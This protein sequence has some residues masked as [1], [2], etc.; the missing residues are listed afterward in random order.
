MAVPQTSTSLLLANTSGTTACISLLSVPYFSCKPLLAEAQTETSRGIWAGIS[1]R[2]RVA[3]LAAVSILVYVNSLLNGFTLDDGMYILGSKAVTGFDVKGL[4]TPVAFNNAFRP[5]TFFSFAVNW[6]LNGSKPFG[7]VFADLLLNAAT[8]LLLYLVLRTLLENMPRG[9][10]IA[11]VAA[12]LFAV[13]PIHT[14]AVASISNRSEILATGF[15]FAAWLFH[16][17]EKPALAVV[18]FVLAL[19]SKESAVAFLPLVVA[20]D[21]ARGRMQSAAK[22]GVYGIATVLY[23]VLLWHVE[24]GRFG[25]VSVSI[26][27]NPL[28]H[29]PTKLR[30][31][32]A[33]CIAWKYVGLLVYPAHLSSDYSYNAIKLYA[34]WK[35]ALPA[36]AATIALLGFWGWTFW[37]KQREWFLAIAIFLFT[38]G[39]TCNVLVPTGTIMAERLMYLPSAGF[40]L[41]VALAWAWLVNRQMKV[42][43]ILLVILV[44]A[45]G[46]RTMA[47]NLNWRDNYS[48]FATD[49]L[50]A[51]GS[52]KLHSNL[53]GQYMG[54]G[55][56]DDASRE[57]STAISIYPDL[58]DAEGYLGVIESMKGNDTEARKWLE[59]ALAGINRDNPNYDYISVNLAGVLI[60]LHDND[61]ALKIL[62]EIIGKSPNYSRAW[63]NRAVIHFGRGEAEQARSDAE[64]A[65]RLDSGNAQAANLLNLVAPH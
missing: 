15:L 61:Q 44:A 40:C 54:R 65:L 39:V 34:D 60:K 3:L 55:Q 10:L 41:F 23:L 51:T 45:F 30:V 18:F 26:L 64:T 19:F 13:H 17:K 8:V 22:Y 20:G 32:N 12:L 62:D 2:T 52:A 14:E 46:V 56:L 24:G 53:G 11:W 37:T 33:V 49:V 58:P 59:K 38:F 4:F 27:D 25:P 16:L 63:S 48:L 6:L 42:A 50:S 7:Y 43:W 29:L 35:Q 31:L 57:L 1:E 36:I 21:Y 9:E 5:V 28:R 47:R